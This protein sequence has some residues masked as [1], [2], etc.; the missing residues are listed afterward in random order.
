M[1]ILKLPPIVLD[2]IAT[3]VLVSAIVA[4]FLGIIPSGLAQTV[5]AA[6]LAYLSGRA[7]TELR[8]RSIIR[9]EIR[10]ESHA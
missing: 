8:V 1:M 7:V 6:V 10:R 9:E 4:S 5:I 3:I 2:A